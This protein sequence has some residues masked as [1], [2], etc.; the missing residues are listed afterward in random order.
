MGSSSERAW[1]RQAFAE[2]ETAG[3]RNTSYRDA[4]DVQVTGSIALV[5]N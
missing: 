2:A 1:S 5:A 3:S 4:R